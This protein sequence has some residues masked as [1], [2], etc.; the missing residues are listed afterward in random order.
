MKLKLPA[1]SMR[2]VHNNAAAVNSTE[3][4]SLQPATQVSNISTYSLL[5]VLDIDIDV[6]TW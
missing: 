4:K 2:L 6:L 1:G 5:T 3:V